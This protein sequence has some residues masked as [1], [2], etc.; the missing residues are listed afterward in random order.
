[1]WVTGASSGIGEYIALCLAE[2]GCRLVLSARREEVLEQVKQ[3]CLQKSE[4]Y[5]F[6]FFSV[7]IVFMLE[8]L[9][10]HRVQCR[11]TRAVMNPLIWEFSMRVLTPFPVASKGCQSPPGVYMF[12]ATIF[13]GCY[14]RFL[15]SYSCCFTSHRGPSSFYVYVIFTCVYSL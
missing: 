15:Y 5:F 9:S 7:L 3:R 4:S 2:A 12:V 11:L 6:L 14:C 1:M 10:Y 13:S 8:Y